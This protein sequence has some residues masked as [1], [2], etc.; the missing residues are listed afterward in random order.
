MVNNKKTHNHSISTAKTTYP[1]GL[2][3]VIAIIPT[4]LILSAIAILSS[5]STAQLV[6]S[7]GTPPLRQ[8]QQQDLND[9]TFHTANVTIDG[10]IIQ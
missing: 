8:Q 7:Q 1:V 3:M 5:V 4:L 6:Y 9:S 10:M 2:T